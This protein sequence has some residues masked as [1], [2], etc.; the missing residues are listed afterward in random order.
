MAFFKPIFL[1][2]SCLISGSC[3]IVNA[4]TFLG[5]LYLVQPIYGYIMPVLIVS[6]IIS[7]IIIITV[8]SGFDICIFHNYPKLL[9]I[10]R[11]SMVSSTNTILLAMASCDFLT[12]ACPAPW[13]IYTYSMDGHTTMKWTK[14]SCYLFELCVETAPQLFRTTSI[15]LTMVLAVQ[16]YLYICK[17]AA[18]K[19]LCTLAKT[20]QVIL[21]LIS[22]SF[23]LTIPRMGDRIY[24]IENDGKKKFKI[25]NINFS[26]SFSPRKSSWRTKYLCRE[27]C[28]LGKLPHCGIV[29]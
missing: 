18:A 16:R 17:A 13:Y 2:P 24:S 7:S 3:Y 22:L 9:I 14:I 15:W 25:Q 4:S 5:P 23:I 12:I 6:T 28:N 21:I 20:K 1:V 29:L 26:P 10:I 8:L 19:N 27:F 11:P